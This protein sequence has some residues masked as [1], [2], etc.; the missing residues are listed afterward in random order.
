MNQSSNM[1][2]HI[3]HAARDI[4]QGEKHVHEHNVKAVRENLG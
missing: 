2:K 3:G 4:K 1:V